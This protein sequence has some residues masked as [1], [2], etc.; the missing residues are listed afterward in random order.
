MKRFFFTSSSLPGS[1][2]AFFETVIA[3]ASALR[4]L[5]AGAS[6]SLS[7]SDEDSDVPDEVASLPDSS[8]D[9][10]CKGQYP[11]RRRLKRE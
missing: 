5:G 10:A 3:S 9:E 8:S 6:S 4:F 11:M 1:V 2:F 7:S